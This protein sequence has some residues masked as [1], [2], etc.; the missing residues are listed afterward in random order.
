M[1]QVAPK[2]EWESRAKAGTQ[3][4]TKGRIKQAANKFGVGFNESSMLSAGDQSPES[5]P[6]LC[7]HKSVSALLCS[8][9]CVNKPVPV[10][11]LEL[12]AVPGKTIFQLEFTPVSLH[13]IRTTEVLKDFY[14]N[15][16]CAEQPYLL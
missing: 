3:Q 15:S 7:Y 2:Q 8:Y 11:N 10:K 16:S 4:F 6:G 9:A 14:W 1:V 12:M 5:S 13:E